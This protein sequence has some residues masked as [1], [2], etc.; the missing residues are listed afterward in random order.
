MLLHPS[1]FKVLSEAVVPLELS[2]TES[3]QVVLIE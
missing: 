2:D 1:L 3:L